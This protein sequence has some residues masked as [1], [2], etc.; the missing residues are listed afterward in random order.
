MSKSNINRRD[1][2]KMTGVALGGAVLASCA[3]KI[4]TTPAA[5]SVPATAA[6]ATAA[7]ATAAPVVVK[8]YQGKLVITSFQA[9]DMYQSVVD[10]IEAKFPGVKVDWKNLTDSKYTELFAAAELAGDQ[11]DVLHLNGQDVRRYALG[12]KLTDASTLGVDFKRF[13]PVGIQTYTVAGKTWAL[14]VGGISGFT[15]LENK[16]SLA[17]I[18]V[19]KEPESYEELKAMAPE[20]KK[21]GISPFVHCGKE[22]YL[23]PVWFFWAYAQSTGNK[24]LEYTV[25]TLSGNRKW[26]DPETVS[27]LEMV[28][29]YSQDGLF[30]EGV[31][32]TSRDAAWQ[33][34]S[35]GKAAFYYD[36]S[37]YVGRFRKEEKDIPELDMSLIP[38]LRMGSD[39]NVKRELPGGTGNALSLYAKV[40]PSRMEISK[41]VIDLFSSDESVAFMNKRDGDAV[42]TNANVAASTDPIS[43]KYANECAEFQKTYLDWNWPP[44]ITRSFQEQLQALVAGTTK[45]DAAAATIQGVFDQ[46]VKDGYKFQN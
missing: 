4:V 37:S 20:L 16:K 39:K 5:T 36:H 46:L 35:T 43:V 40:D 41:Q 32:S 27:A 6:P 8:G 12:G 23:W 33:I 24:S 9:L 22:I 28:Y 25:D 13:R 34:F 44:E 17:K 42:S 15:F 19:T 31:N 26:T 21:A 10:Q 38:P 29:R 14:P 3:P 45:P 11:M 7:A 30:N 1:F 18:G 2:L